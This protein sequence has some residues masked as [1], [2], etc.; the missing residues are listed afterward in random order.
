M[1]K[2]LNKKGSVLFLVVVVMS[3]LLVVASATYYIVSNQRQSVE[4]HYN[5]EQSYQTAYSVNKTVSDYLLNQQQQI[6]GKSKVP[7]E[8][9]IYGKIA[10]LN[11]G[12]TITFNTE[13]EEKGTDAFKNLG[14]GDFE[15]TIKKTKG[16]ANAED[17]EFEVTTK[18]TVNGETTSLTQVWKVKLSASETKYFTRFLTSTGLG[19]PTDT[20]LKVQ[21]IYGENYFENEFTTIDRPTYSHKSIYS[22]GTLIDKGFVYESDFTDKEIVVFGNYYRNGASE[23]RHLKRILVGKNM[24]VKSGS[25][26]I[27]NADA[28]YVCGNLTIDAPFN[29]SSTVFFVQGDCHFS[30]K[31]DGS[32]TIYVAGDVYC[33]SGLTIADGVTIRYANKLYDGNGNETSI[34]RAQ[35]I[36]ASEI[37]AQINSRNENFAEEGKDQAGWT[38][39]VAYISNN[40]AIGTYK[41]WD[42]LS[43]FETKEKTGE[44]EDGIYARVPTFDIE[45]EVASL[46]NNGTQDVSNS[47][48]ENGKKS[49]IVRN[50]QQVELVIRENCKYLKPNNLQSVSNFGILVDAT[51]SDIYIYLDPNGSDE[52]AFTSSS[53]GS[54][55]ILV[56]GSHAVIFV[57]PE[58]ITFKMHDRSLIGHLELAKKQTGSS[59]ELNLVTNC[60][61]A[62]GNTDTWKNFLEETSANYIFK[63][64]EDN[65]E[66]YT[67]LDDSKFSDKVHN[68]IF[69]VSRGDNKFDLQ[70]TCGLFGYIYAPKTTMDIKPNGNNVKF[71]GGL[72]VGGFKYDHQ[73]G[74]LAFCQPYDEYSE[75]GANIVADLINFAGGDEIGDGNPSNGSKNVIL[76]PG[77]YK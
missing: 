9:T 21:Q 2:L 27:L 71:L 25:S 43:L 32:C 64:I 52:F 5:S 73:D 67:V 44:A 57:L 50:G 11:E 72:I 40:T 66:Q 65:G 22:S 42:A 37:E 13:D 23:G 4:V 74:Y 46:S 75:R 16:A 7:Y 17:M 77:G 36:T 49:Y 41:E 62:Q 76:T 10:A 14:L 53:Y 31:I 59:D 61:L 15:I 38:S 28:V 29:G 33:S 20:Y 60:D 30:N 24:E 68:N 51:D 19:V 8:N 56:K 1:K 34:S 3:I 58:G 54:N 48:K 70:A 18:S 69:L 63:T 35:P 45:Q 39:V 12:G 55:N 47:A 26:E 6:N